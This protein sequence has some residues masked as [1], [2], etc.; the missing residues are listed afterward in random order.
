MR[1][2]IWLAAGLAPVCAAQNLAARLDPILASSPALAGAMV[3]LQVI[4]LSDG[5]ILYSHNSDQHFVPASNMKLFTSALA[6]SRLGPDYRFTTEIRSG[7]PIDSNGCL[8]GD[9]ALVGGGDPSLSGRAYPYQYERGARPGGSYSL[10]AIEDFADQLAALGL[11]HVRGD[12][13]GDDRRYVW[14][15]HPGGWERGDAEWEYGAP[16]SALMLDD[17]SLAITLRP[18]ARPG[19]LA[20]IWLT[21][22]FEYFFI[23]NRVTTGA[24]PE[25]KVQFEREPS[26]RELHVWG[27]LPVGGP[28]LSELLAVDDPALYAAGALRTIARMFRTAAPSRWF[29]QS[30]PRRRSRK[31]CKLWTR[32]ARTCTRRCYCAR[33][34]LRKPGRERATRGYPNCAIS[35]VKWGCRRTAV[36]SPTA[37]D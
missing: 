29:W 23:D 9:L 36:N 32:S 13:A 10:R 22:P 20:Q 4:R 37:P 3:G 6:L 2:L 35:C 28:G 8:D 24:G 21:P 5:A 25:R 14:E 33:S 27:V 30:G 31:F 1:Y 15:P 26:G 17:N 11:K 18:G 7:R 16:V 12:I 34:R 19:D